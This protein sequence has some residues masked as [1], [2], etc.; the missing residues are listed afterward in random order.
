LS[1]G[2]PGTHLGKEAM[3][4]YLL[5]SQMA[6]LKDLSGLGRESIVEAAVFGLLI[7][8]RSIPELGPGADSG[9]GAGRG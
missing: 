2:G 7:T 6:E 9:V 4:L 1:E 3:P 5:S 8:L